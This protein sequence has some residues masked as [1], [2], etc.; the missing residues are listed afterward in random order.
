MQEVQE[1]QG[2]RPA[3]WIHSPPTRDPTLVECPPG[4]RKHMM[5]MQY[6]LQIGLCALQQITAIWKP[7]T[8]RLVRKEQ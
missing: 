3:S 8:W 7:E 1:V 5:N 4:I 6:N 2:W